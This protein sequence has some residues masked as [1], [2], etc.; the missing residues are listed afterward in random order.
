M[1]LRHRAEYAQ[2]PQT[3]CYLYV[4]HMFHSFVIFWNYHR[5]GVSFVNW[6]LLV[7]HIAPLCFL[8]TASHLIKRYTTQVLTFVIKHP[9]K[10]YH[11]RN[12]FYDLLNCLFIL[13]TTEKI[14]LLSEWFNGYDF[15]NYIVNIRS[16]DILILNYYEIYCCK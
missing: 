14:T 12:N 10:R 13:I 7:G 3:W 8:L 4:S 16:L 11:I 5:L 6:L 9:L 1:W 15:F 2:K